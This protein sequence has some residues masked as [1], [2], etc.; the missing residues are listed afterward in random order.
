M[1][2]T[3][4]C[5]L[6]WLTMESATKR[7]SILLVVLMAMTVPIVIQVHLFLISII[8]VV[9]AQSLV[10]LDKGIVMM[11]LNVQM[12]LSVDIAIVDLASLRI[13]IVVCSKTLV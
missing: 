13:L 6:L 5:M 2:W 7:T 1:A 9:V 3:V 11:M 4:A 12:D 10:Y 8:I